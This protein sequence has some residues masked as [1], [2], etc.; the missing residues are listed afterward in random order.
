[1]TQIKIGQALD[2][3]KTGFIIKAAPGIAAGML[4]RVLKEKRVDSEKAT[5]WVMDNTS[6]W[7]NLGPEFQEALRN[8]SEQVKN[9]DWLTADWVIKAIKSDLPAVASLFLGWKKANNWLVRQV[10]IIREKVVE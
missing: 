6:F 5:K 1:M 10:E 9:L 8:L 3:L 4:I 7:D 2:F